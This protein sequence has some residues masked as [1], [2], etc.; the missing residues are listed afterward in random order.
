MADEG[1]VV[2]HVI[3]RDSSNGKLL[4]VRRLDRDQYLIP[5][6]HDAWAVSQAIAGYEDDRYSY[7]GAVVY[8]S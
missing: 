1:R 8:P 5:P 3:V 7:H 4:T 6:G 2:I